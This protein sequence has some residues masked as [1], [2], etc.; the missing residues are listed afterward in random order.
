[1]RGFEYAN[2]SLRQGDLQAGYLLLL[3]SACCLNE[4]IMND[5]AC[6]KTQTTEKSSETEKKTQKKPDGRLNVKVKCWKRPNHLEAEIQLCQLCKCT[7]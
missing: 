6:A 4:L 7:E 3:P 5:D 2:V 1:M